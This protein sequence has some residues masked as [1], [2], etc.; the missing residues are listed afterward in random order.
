[1]L[2]FFFTKSACSF[3]LAVPAPSFVCQGRLNMSKPCNGIA[4]LQCEQPFLHCGRTCLQQQLINWHRIVLTQLLLSFLCHLQY[5]VGNVLAT[6][7]VVHKD[8]VDP[9]Q[10]PTST[11]EVRQSTRKPPFPLWQTDH[12]SST[13][14]SSPLCLCHLTDTPLSQ[15]SRQSMHNAWKRGQWQPETR[16]QI[17]EAC[18]SFSTSSQ[19]HTARRHQHLTSTKPTGWI[20]SERS[21]QLHTDLHALS[22]HS[23]ARCFSCLQKTT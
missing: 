15:L 7:S 13:L 17:A 14:S 21:A 6:S 8:I 22:F 1:M 5:L 9:G 19:S 18:V 20:V 16:R 2:G 12:V 23:S 4:V 10:S 3:N 11:Q